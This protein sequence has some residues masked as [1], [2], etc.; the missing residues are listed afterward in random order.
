MNLNMSFSSSDFISKEEKEL[1]TS[2]LDTIIT[3][4]IRE[5]PQKVRAGV[6]KETHC[7]DAEQGLDFG[8]YSIKSFLEIIKF[9]HF[10][11]TITKKQIN[12]QREFISSIKI[13]DKCLNTKIETADGYSDIYAFFFKNY[14][15]YNIKSKD[16]RSRNKN[17][18][19]IT[20]HNIPIEFLFILKQLSSLNGDQNLECKDIFKYKSEINSL[21]KFSKYHKF[22]NEEMEAFEYEKEEFERQ[23]RI[24]IKQVD[25]IYEER[26]RELM[27]KEDMIE[28][29][30]ALIEAEKAKLKLVKMK[31][32]KMKVQLDLER[33]ELNEQKREFM[34]MKAE[35][36]DL[37]DYFD[38]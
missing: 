22:L 30:A 28:K 31:L 20:K 9:H 17:S 24:R 10:N 18:Y 23:Q 15:V 13:D 38:H 14:L 32:D 33:E 21:D 25:S 3:E 11:N 12:L 4:K 35:N 6:Q 1:F 36:L 19:L 27:K 37:D 8:N 2:E 16:P 7:V 26:L 34:A 29:H 5:F